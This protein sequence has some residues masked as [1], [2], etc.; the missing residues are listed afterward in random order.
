MAHNAIFFE[1]PRSALQ[2][3]APVGFSWTTLFFGPFPLLFRG[4][5]A[6][7]LISLGLTV[8]TLHTSNLVLSFLLNRLYI[9]DLLKRGFKAR[10]VLH[11]SSDEVEKELGL[12]LPSLASSL[13]YETQATRL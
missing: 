1:N 9:Q 2:R 5:L 6:W 8:L 7:F 13:F 12:E 10:S 11:G 3:R 4:E